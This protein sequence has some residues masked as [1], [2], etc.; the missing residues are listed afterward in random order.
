MPSPQKKAPLDEV[1]HRLSHRDFFG[2][3]P[4][5]D[6]AGHVTNMP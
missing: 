1:D 6:E 4:A 3:E 5:I 2:I